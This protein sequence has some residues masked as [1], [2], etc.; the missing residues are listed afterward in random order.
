MVGFLH[1]HSVEV[2]DTLGERCCLF[3][4]AKAMEFALDVQLAVPAA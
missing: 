4:N 1:E 2:K 3:E